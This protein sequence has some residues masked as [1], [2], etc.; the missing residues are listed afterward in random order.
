M[1]IYIYI[2]IHTYIH[3]YR[4][5][6]HLFRIGYNIRR[7]TYTP[8]YKSYFQDLKVNSENSWSPPPGLGFVTHDPTNSEIQNLST[9][10]EIGRIIKPNISILA[11][12][13]HRGARASP[14]TVLRIHRSKNLE[15]RF[16]RNPICSGDTT[17][18][19]NENLLESSPLKSRVIYIYIYIYIYT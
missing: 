15:S 12:A 9:S 4:C 2:Y 17:P 16:R 6:R 18:R 10:T 7:C 11:A 1:H 8:G 14:H 13:L 19:I 3:T 5:L